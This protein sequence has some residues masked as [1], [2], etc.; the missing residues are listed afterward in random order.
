MMSNTDFSK[1]EL[2]PLDPARKMRSEIQFF[3][4]LAQQLSIIFLSPNGETNVVQHLSTNDN[5]SNCQ[6][7]EEREHQTVS[8]S[9]IC[10]QVQSTFWQIDNSAFFNHMPTLS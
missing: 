7:G 10:M 4:W 6:A 9:G 2:N 8:C 3:S 1:R 5:I